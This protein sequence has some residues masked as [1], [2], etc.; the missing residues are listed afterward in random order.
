[1]SRR[2]RTILLLSYGLP[3]GRPPAEQQPLRS[4]PLLPALFNPSLKASSFDGVDLA[5]IHN[6]ENRG[7]AW[8]GETRLRLFLGMRDV[9]MRS[10]ICAR[11]DNIQAVSASGR[12][13]DSDRAPVF[14]H[15]E[16]V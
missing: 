15:T 6:L 5:A 10:V 8:D 16:I 11:S 14:G 7:Q 1:M 12:V 13:R 3:Q 2:R 9:K 4:L